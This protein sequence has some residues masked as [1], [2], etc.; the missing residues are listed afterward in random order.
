MN[1]RVG[2]GHLTGLLW[3]SALLC[4]CG[5]EGAIHTHVYDASDVPEPGP[6]VYYVS[7]VISGLQGEGLVLEL[8]D[9]EQIQV[10]VDGTFRFIDSPLEVGEAYSVEIANQ[11]RIPSQQCVVSGASGVVEASNIEDLTVTC[12]VNTFRVGGL[13]SGMAGEGLIVSLN[14]TWEVRPESNGDLT[15]Q[16]A[17]LPDGTSFLVEVLAQPEGP[18]QTC[19][20][21]N[22]EGTL[23]G[24]DITNLD[25]QCTTNRYAVGGSVEGLTGTGL[26]LSMGTSDLEIPVNGEFQFTDALVEDGRLFEITVSTQ[27]TEPNQL[28]TIENG[29][30]MIAGGDYAGA[31][32]S[33]VDEVLTGDDDN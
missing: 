19:I 5:T 7:G 20:V 29:G 15:F 17:Y 14:E 24:G 28:C 4:S 9:D 6:E 27:P 1:H 25:V 30:G 21:E 26:I 10:A 12:T 18:N 13:L 2:W 3:L 32:V 8:N 11:P 23:N 16:S 22:G 31:S 33:C